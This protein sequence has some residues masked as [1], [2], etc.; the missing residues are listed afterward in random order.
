MDNI[1]LADRLEALVDEYDDTIFSADPLG[2]IAR[3]QFDIK[4]Q[5]SKWTHENHAKII[6]ALRQSSPDT[7]DEIERLR[8]RIAELEASALLVLPDSIEGERL[9]P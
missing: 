2:S 7:A 1:S 9:K 6:A 4:M 3:Q 8:A 5:L